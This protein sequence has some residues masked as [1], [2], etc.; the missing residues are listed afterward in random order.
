MRT[1]TCDVLA[2]ARSLNLPEKKPQN[3]KPL[4]FG[5]ATK[6]GCS[7]HVSDRA[8]NPE[9]DMCWNG[10]LHWGERLEGSSFKGKKEMTGNGR[11]CWLERPSA[12]WSHT[13]AHRRQR[14]GS[15]RGVQRLWLL[16]GFQLH[17]AFRAGG[18]EAECHY[19]T[20]SDC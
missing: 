13:S 16:N 20:P 11:V 17:L 14:T 19:Q 8:E 15:L 2:R 12:A 5:T 1:E 18:A 9:E 4:Q 7:G 6:L 3:Q 10:K